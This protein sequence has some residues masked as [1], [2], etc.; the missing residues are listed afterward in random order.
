MKSSDKV[1]AV[2]HRSENFTINDIK[3]ESNKD[4]K[5]ELDGMKSYRVNLIQYNSNSNAKL[6]DINTNS[7]TNSNMLNVQQAIKSKIDNSKDISDI[8]HMNNYNNSNN[9]N[10]NNKVIDNTINVSN[11]QNTSSISNINNISVNNNTNTNINRNNNYSNININASREGIRTNDILVSYFP[12]LDN[13]LKSIKNSNNNSNQLNSNREVK[14]E[15]NRTVKFISTKQSNAAFNFNERSPKKNID[16]ENKSLKDN[17][18]LN[19]NRKNSRS[20]KII[21]TEITNNDVDEYNYDQVNDERASSYHRN[22]LNESMVSSNILTH[23]Y[24]PKMIQ[25]IKNENQSFYSSFNESMSRIDTQNN[26]L[27]QSFNYDNSN[28]S[29]YNGNFANTGG[30]NFERE[31]DMQNPVRY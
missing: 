18:S 8:N 10:D 2:T 6:H 11:I 17:N 4:Y 22:D 15:T 28:Y 29:N 12:E 9:D 7:N 13:D 14:S 26:I 16:I 23:V 24:T 27:T 3:F 5:N 1:N 31:M 21:D 20:D 30:S 25:N 19:N